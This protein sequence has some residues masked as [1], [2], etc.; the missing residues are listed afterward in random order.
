LEIKN[1]NLGST[2]VTNSDFEKLK[3]INEQ[4][5]KELNA[6]RKMVKLF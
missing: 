5:N 6:L 1:L 3:K 4:L 2:N